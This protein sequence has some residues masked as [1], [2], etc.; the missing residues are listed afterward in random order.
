MSGDLATWVGSLGTVGTLVAALIQL[1]L[2]DRA[3]RK[4]QR[5]AHA[6]LIS[7]WVIGEHKQETYA[8]IQNGSH[9]PI[10]NI[11]VSLVIQ[12][13]SGPTKGEDVKTSHNKNACHVLPP[14]THVVNIGSGWGGMCRRPGVEVAFTDAKGRH[15]V[16]RC[17]GELERLKHNPIL[18]MGIA[19]PFI[20]FKVL[21]SDYLE[22]G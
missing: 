3:R 22:R 20:E 11:V 12:A 8:K 18:E 17:S 13:G 14:G 1:A 16:R 9:V 2:S 7:A 4:E 5:I 10:Y 15:W 6:A 21:P 19:Q